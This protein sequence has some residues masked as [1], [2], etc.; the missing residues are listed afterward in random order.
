MRNII[1][2]LV[3]MSFLIS[4][5]QKDTVEHTPK[6]PIKETSSD[7]P[8][9]RNAEDDNN[10]QSAGSQETY[11]QEDPTHN[12]KQYSIFDYSKHDIILGNPDAKV[13]V[14]EYSAPTC[15]HCAYYKSNVFE[16]L[17]KKYIDTN[18]IAYV[19]REFVGNKQ[20]QAASILAHCAGKTRFLKFESI[21]YARQD[22]WVYSNNYKDI[23]T[24]IGKIGGV[25]EEQYNQ[26]LNDK[27][28]SEDLYKLTMEVVNYP[29]FIGTPTFFVG[30]KMHNKPYSVT[31]LSK[32]IDIELQRHL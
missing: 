28:L 8:A 13:R 19:I 3:I 32:A 12:Y 29:N 21:I 20:D 2:G 10:I 7:K 18:Q 24:N 27:S 6:E 16:Y 25:S 15:A 26:C 9:N 5:G 4:F 22:S 23:L 30:E 31:E 1:I 14:F 11:K 17:K